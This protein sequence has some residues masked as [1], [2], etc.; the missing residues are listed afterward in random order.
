MKWQ[1]TDQQTCEQV[2]GTALAA[3]TNKKSNRIQF[4]TVH[5]NLY[6]YRAL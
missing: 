3:R 4:G 5:V 2:F 1:E 6:L